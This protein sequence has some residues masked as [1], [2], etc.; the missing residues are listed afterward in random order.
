M[1]PDTLSTGPEFSSPGDSL[2]L[3]PGPA[4]AL[5]PAPAHPNLPA[6]LPS[7]ALYSPLVSGL[8]SALGLT[9]QAGPVPGGI[10]SPWLVY[11]GE[12]GETLGTS[13]LMELRH[14]TT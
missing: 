4:P 6:R 13:L 3:F 11:Q 12:I 14:L 8:P 10:R 7:N 9:P 5:G 1:S 2:P